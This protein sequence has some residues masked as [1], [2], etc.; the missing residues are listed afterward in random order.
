MKELTD[1]QK[2]F[3]LAKINGTDN[4]QDL[5]PNNGWTWPK[6]TWLQKRLSEI[7][8]TPGASP[9]TTNH[10]R[11]VPYDTVITSETAGRAY[12]RD[13]REEPFIKE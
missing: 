9:L 1:T 6:Q 2:I 10:I 11:P 13:P 7:T 4:R 8:N 3:L 5:L 12:G